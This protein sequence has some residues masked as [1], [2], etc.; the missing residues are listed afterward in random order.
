MRT[1]RGRPSRGF[2]LIEVL[3]VIA[4]IALLVSILLPAIAAARNSGRKAVSMSRL[5]Q[6]NI[7]GQS[8]KEANKGKLPIT[9]TFRRGSAPSAM[10]PR[11][12]GWCS[13]SFAGKNCS[14]Y[15]ATGAS[16]GFD[17]E[18][19][20]RPL[21]PYIYPDKDWGAPPFPSFLKK[22]SPARQLKGEAFHDPSDRATH[23]RQW[24]RPTPGISSYD[25]VGISY[26]W[27]FGW[28]FQ[29]YP[30]PIRDF[31]Q[32]FD[33]GT[34][35]LATSD[36]F[37]PSRMVWVL[38]EVAAVTVFDTDPKLQ[39]I[40]GYND[41]NKGMLGFL[42]GHV[43]YHAVSPGRKIESLRTDRYTFVFDD[44]KPPGGG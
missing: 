7:A 34:Q 27:S 44:M 41:I 42:D 12:I 3:V 10:F 32:A 6:I 25:D 11:E 19:D 14:D 1:R 31:R 43:A 4:I 39:L 35:A 5:Q 13:W 22:D 8:Y 29:V 23:Q 16:T 38:D 40:N 17:V 2:T 9:E 26:Q 21:N 15:W 37:I 24:P 36:S 28:W 33:F 20:D 30:R 18:A